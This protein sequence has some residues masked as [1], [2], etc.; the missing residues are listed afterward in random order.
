[1]DLLRIFIDEQGNLQFSV[2]WWPVLAAALLVILWL[3]IRFGSIRFLKRSF[4][5]NEAEIG[6][7]SQK[8]KIKPN[9]T[10]SQVAYQLWVELSTRKIG[11]PIDFENDV[12]V[13]VYNSWYEFFGLTRELIKGIPIQ[14]IRRDENTRQLV[15]I[16]VAVLNEGLRPHLTLWQARFRQWYKAESEEAANRRLSPQELQKK[17]P[18]YSALTKDMEKVNQRLIRYRSLLNRIASE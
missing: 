6:I 8:I 4:E 17:F 9:Y 15:R 2:S 1:M 18:D 13:E 12:I 16:A 7:G 14:L 3:L 11:L 5:I 10:D